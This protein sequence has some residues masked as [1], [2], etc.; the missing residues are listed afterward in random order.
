MVYRDF[1]NTGIKTSVLGFGAMR[2]PM[3]EENGQNLVDETLAGPMI[4]RAYEGGVN[5]F[6]TA[7]G[8]CGE[9]SQYALGRALKDVRDKVYISTKLP[10]GHV[11]ETAD[12][13]RL[14]N[15]S[16]RRL[17]TDYVDF[18]HFHG[19]GLN[20]YQNKILPLKLLNKAE[21]AIA[22]GR[23]RH[24]SFSFHDNPDNMKRLADTGM[25]S[26]VLCQYNLVDQSNGEAMAYCREKGLGITV[27]GPLGGGN[28]VNGGKDFLSKFDARAQSAAELA[29]KFVW[30]NP[31]VCCALSG[32]RT[33]AEV[34]ENL[35]FAEGTDNIP[36]Q[37]WKGLAKT[38]D[39]LS[40]LAKLYC[41][42]CRYCDVC[43][44]GIKPFKALT[45]F[46]RW[47]VWGLRES[48]F[49]RY[50]DAIEKGELNIDACEECGACAAKCP[51][52]IDIPAE[53]KR[54]GRAFEEGK[55]TTRA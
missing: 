19:I 34:E 35:A 3:K 13:D 21:K 18:Y 6:D 39:E 4:R 9:Q 25:F 7:W 31:N 28:I 52:K 46:N 23:I 1:G 38:S 29:W 30:G 27:M 50:R 16:L 54:I 36:E 44:Q 53:L 32:M 47:Q 26:S 11:H 20:D 2:L 40:Q 15:E 45:E 5:Y 14:L 10:L 48:A 8:Y 24:L 41:T 55:M 33:L 49:R 51:Q 42:G 17:G 37:E 43:P 12:F 22:D